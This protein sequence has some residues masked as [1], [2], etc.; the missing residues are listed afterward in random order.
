MIRTQYEGWGAVFFAWIITSGIFVFWLF[1]NILLGVIVGTIL[2]WVFSLIFLGRWVVAGLRAF[3]LDVAAGNLY[4]IGAAAGFLSS[5]FKF[6]IK[7][8]SWDF[9]KGKEA[10]KYV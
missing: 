1:S 6:S 2:G 3:R 7:S 4:Q 8:P 9:K 10:T 5:F